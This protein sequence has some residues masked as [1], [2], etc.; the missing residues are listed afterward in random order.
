MVKV[1]TEGHQVSMGWA[2]PWSMILSPFSA[3]TLLAGQQEGHLACKC[4]LLIDLLM[5][6]ILLEFCTSHS[7]SC[8]RRLHYL[9]PAIKSRMETFWHRLYSGFPGKWPFVV[10]VVVVGIEV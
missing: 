4:W 2:S 8:Y 5:V 9:F 7:S 6:T 10:V 1:T 3:L